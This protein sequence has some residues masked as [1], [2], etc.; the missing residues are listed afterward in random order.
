MNTFLP[1]FV[2]LVKFCVVG[3]TGMIIDFSTTWL[4][5]ENVQ[6]IN[7]LQTLPAFYWLRSIIM[8][9]T[10]GGHLSPILKK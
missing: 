2:K 10:G 7:I 9:G 3:F 6:L 4:L 1:L 5:K 8:C